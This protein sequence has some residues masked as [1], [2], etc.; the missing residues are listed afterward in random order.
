M[1]KAQLA[2]AKRCKP[3]TVSVA[4]S[5]TRPAL[6]HSA[7]ADMFQAEIRTSKP[8]P[9]FAAWLCAMNKVSYMT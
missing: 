6:P 9:E 5:P 7:K 2:E 8:A 4:T 3:Q 1:L